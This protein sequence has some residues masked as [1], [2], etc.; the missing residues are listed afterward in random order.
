MKRFYGYGLPYIDIQDLRGKLIV[1]EGSDG[2][3]RSTQIF[4][5]RSWLELQG[6]GVTETG[7]T[8]SQLMS[9]TIHLAKEGHNM[10]ALTFNLLYA[11][12]FADRLEHEVIP[13]LR[14][15]FIV[16]SDRYIYTAFA[17]AAVRGADMEWMSRLYGFALVPDLV[18]YLKTD[19][20]TLVHRRLM[21]GSMDYWEAGL[22]LNPGLDPYESFIK[23]QTKL[24]RQYNRLAKEFNFEIVNA[25]RSVDR[26]QKDLRDRIACVLGIPCD[27]T[28]ASLTVSA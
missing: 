19:V 21:S 10:N 9:Q 15:G 16:L 8:R 28:A 24:L 4:A 11:T 14:S 5:L 20:H 13:A 2:V 25:R 23:Y 26:I 18:L 6:F 1:I 7:W 22:D 17:R 27:K 3:G 12:D